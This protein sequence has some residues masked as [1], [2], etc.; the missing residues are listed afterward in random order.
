MREEPSLPCHVIAGPLGVG[1]T[2]AILDYLAR[3]AATQRVGVLVNDFGPVGLDGEIVAGADGATGV[4]VTT[5]PGGC[6]CCAAAEGLVTSIQ[7]MLASD[8][9]RLIIEP[10]GMADPAQVLDLLR[11]MEGE[12]RL[13]LRP[14]IALLNAT[15]F[16]PNRA[17]QMPFFR[18]M[19]DA[20]DILVLNRCD[21]A[22]PETAEAFRQWAAELEPPKLRVLTTELGHLADD[23]FEIALPPSAADR[24]DHGHDPDRHATTQQTGALT[25]D[26]EQVFRHGPLV[27]V[28]AQIAEEGVGDT[29]LD[30][31]KG[32]FRTDRGWYL[33]QIAH[34]ELQVRDTPP[35]RESSVEWVAASPQVTADQLAATLMP[36]GPKDSA[37]A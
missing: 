11:Q 29:P 2:T 19:A 6:V 31:L 23:L 18:H 35:R 24:T 17:S 22:D 13:E 7:R 30:R 3:H 9:D 32:I 37:S 5:V 34:G 16:E 1:K 20:A 21:T 28:L 36:A 4:Q 26:K 33:L 12:S 14:T 15:E 10:S 25:W 27:Q 8:I